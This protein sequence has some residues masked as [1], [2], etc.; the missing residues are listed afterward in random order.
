MLLLGVLMLE[1]CNDLDSPM[2]IAL[3]LILSMTVGTVSYHKRLYNTT[4]DG[5][6]EGVLMGQISMGTMWVL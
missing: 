1:L 4:N 3:D 6:L 5:K 2:M